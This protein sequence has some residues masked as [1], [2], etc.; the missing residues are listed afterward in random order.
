MQR[1]N[2]IKESSLTVIG[3]GVF[4]SLLSNN[5]KAGAGLSVN[6]KRIES[7]IFELA[8]FGR[9]ENGRG[10][11]VAYTKGD[12]EGR[13]WIMDLMKKAGLDPTIDAAGNIIGKRKGKNGP[14]ISGNFLCCSLLCSAV[15]LQNTN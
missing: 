8:K 5:K 14:I 12:I 7:R 1:R 11:R 15:F 9:D 13:A 2:F 4:G 10:Y 6:G 3:L